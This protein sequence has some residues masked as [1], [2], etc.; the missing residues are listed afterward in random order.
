MA[1]KKQI[2]LIFGLLIVLVVVWIWVILLS[3]S[4][5]SKE[6]TLVSEVE[7]GIEFKLLLD[8]AKEYETHKGSLAELSYQGDR[9]P[10]S[11]QK[12]KKEEG[13]KTA[14]GIFETFTLKGILW[15]YQKPLA[16]VN[17]EVVKEGDMMEGV[18]IKQIEPNYVV[19]EAE[20][21]EKVLFIEE[22]KVKQENKKIKM[23]GENG[24]KTAPVGVY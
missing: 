2:L 6:E 19:L 22:I 17:G 7:R 14:S 12:G 10:F 3:P 18:K 4:E 11:L 5:K 16:I 24:E 20:G 9:D 1:E 13:K 8:L 21:E 23:E 15:D